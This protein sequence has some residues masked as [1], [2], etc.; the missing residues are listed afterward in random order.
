MVRG[1]RNRPPLSAHLIISTETFHVL[2]PKC[3]E[4]GASCH[5]S[6]LEIQRVAAF[7]GWDF[8]AIPTWGIK[9]LG[10][11]SDPDCAWSGYRCREACTAV[12]LA[13]PGAAPSSQG[14]GE[15]GAPGHAECHI[16]F[17]TLSFASSHLTPAPTVCQVRGVLGFSLS[18]TL[19]L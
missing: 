1:I 14:I 4:R 7:E 10:S 18:E 5:R 16:C 12:M 6:N 15:E 13:S 2:V 11:R 19:F 3:R 9:E 8:S 17:P